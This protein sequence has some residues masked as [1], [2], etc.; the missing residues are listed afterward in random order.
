[1]DVSA[2]GEGSATT[3]ADVS[4]LSPGGRPRVTDEPVI[5][6]GGIGTVANQLDSMINVGVSLVAAVE[7]TGLIARPGR[8]VHADRDGTNIGDGL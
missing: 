8:G 6:E 5:T 7:D 1:M 2:A 3:K 4:L